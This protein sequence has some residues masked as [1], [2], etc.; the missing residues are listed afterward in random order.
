MRDAAQQHS[1]DR[2]A[3]PDAHHDQRRTRLPR[4]LQHRLGDIRHDLVPDLR[5]GCKESSTCS[6]LARSSS[7]TNLRST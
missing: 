5:R 7:P 2:R 3:R 1:A 6:S 4:G